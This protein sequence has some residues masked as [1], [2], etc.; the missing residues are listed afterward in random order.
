MKNVE[1]GRKEKFI[2][3]EVKRRQNNLKN[4]RRAWNMIRTF[5]VKE[6]QVAFSPQ[7]YCV[8]A[9]L[10]PLNYLRVARL[11]NISINFNGENYFVAKI[12]SVPWRMVYAIIQK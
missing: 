7:D 5:K 10:Y 9:Q 12:V 1:N 4:V 2:S 8:A 11:R 6:W 3:K